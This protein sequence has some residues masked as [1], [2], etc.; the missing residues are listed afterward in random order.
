MGRLVQNLRYGMRAWRNSPLFTV[1]AVATLALGIGATSA[2]FTLVD[3]ALLR[4]L[5]FPEPHRLVLVWEDTS[6]FGLK[7]S[8]VSFANYVEWRAQSHAF[9]RMGA[10]EQ[11]S[12]RLTGAGDAQQV[13]GSIVTASLFE[14][15]SV[16]PALGRPFR[17]GEDQPGT[18]KSVILSDGLWE[19]AFGRDPA[20]VGRTIDLNDEKYLVVGVMPFMIA[21][22]TVL[23]LLTLFPS[24]V[25][26]SWPWSPSTAMP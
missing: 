22:L 19:R 25:T 15:L 11:R 8:P 13:Q 5:P 6:M 10:L 26:K 16:H 21:E 1:V 9:E 24:L 18:P 20:I 2:I 12:F 14:A 17:D 4:P 23:A 7:D 3:A